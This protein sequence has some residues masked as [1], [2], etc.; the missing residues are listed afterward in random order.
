MSHRLSVDGDQTWLML[1]TQTAVWGLCSGATLYVLSRTAASNTRTS[2]LSRA[3]K[4]TFVPTDLLSMVC[5]MFQPR[6]FMSFVLWRTF[7]PTNESTTSSRATMSR[8]YDD[9]STRTATTEPPS[10]AKQKD[11]SKTKNKKRYLELLVHNVSHTDL[12]LGLELAASMATDARR[13]NDSCN[14]SSFI[15]CR[16]RFSRFHKYCSKICQNMS[17]SSL[18]LLPCYQRQYD[19]PRYSIILPKAEQGSGDPSDY[20]QHPPTPTGLYLGRPVDVEDNT[21]VRVRGRDQEKMLP[22]MQVRHVF[23]PLL[24]S[25]LPRWKQQIALKHQRDSTSSKVHRVLVLVTG[26]GTPRDTSQDPKANSTA[27]CAD[28]IKHFVGVVDPSITVVQIHSDSNIFRFDDNILFVKEVLLPQIHAYRDAHARGMPYPHEL[29]AFNTPTLQSLHGEE[30]PFQ[31]D[32]RTSF[33]TTLS[34]AD[35]S[36]ARTYAIQCGL[37]DYKPIY[38]HFWQLKTFW[39]EC[40]IVIDD[41]EVHSYAAME[42]VPPVDTNHLPVAPEDN[43][44][45]ARVVDEIKA[46]SR[47]VQQMFRDESHELSRFWL[48]QTR[49]PVLAVLL[50]RSRNTEPII[51]RGTNMEVS[52]PTGS[53]C[54]ERNVIGTALANNPALKRQDL[55]V[56]AVLAVPFQEPDVKTQS[57]FPRT[58]SNASLDETSRKSSIGSEGDTTEWHLTNPLPVRQNASDMPMESSFMMVP[59]VTPTTVIDDDDDEPQM[60]RIELFSAASTQ[61]SM[62]TVLLKQSAKRKDLNPLAPCGACNE[63]LK[64]IAES[65]PYFKILTFTDC[66]CH[67]VYITPCKDS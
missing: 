52:M 31:E 20:L 16:P 56:L 44:D 51:Y 9:K 40:K 2:T 6:L 32:W 29:D 33:T 14:E 5:A 28:L 49:K 21:E 11:R 67:G 45:I 8:N 58:I 57:T 10:K 62:R 46:F 7:W 55:K 53:L 23:F 59:T 35:G 39:H 36:N 1:V 43:A 27:V 13:P 50:V 63:W 30:P 64:K 54:A 26:V 22:N 34:W 60:R 41:I 48:R 24:A 19:S 61:S 3:N 25:L 37:R 12:V 66:Q 4:N 15:L 17:P 47:E 38:Y 65:N 42:L 18:V